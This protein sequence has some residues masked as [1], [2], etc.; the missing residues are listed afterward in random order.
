MTNPRKPLVSRTG[1]TIRSLGAT[2]AALL[3]LSAC[4]SSTPPE[5]VAPSIADTPASVN[6]NEV[7]GPH[8]PADRPLAERK[9]TE[10][11]AKTL[12]RIAIDFGN[13]TS[14]QF[15]A[16]KRG[17]IIVP[18][19]G[20]EASPLVILSHLRAPNCQDRTFAYPCAAGVEEF[21]Y[22]EGM[23]YLGDH[24]AEHGYTVVI[25]D[26]GAA[27]IGADLG[28]P[29]S[30][31]AMWEDIVG[32]M[33]NALR[34]D[35]AGQ[36]TILGT[37]IPRP[38]DFDTVGLVAHSRSGQMIDSAIKVAGQGHMKGVFAYGP[39]YDTVEL[40][41]I[42]PALADVPY[43]A[44]VGSLDSDVG[45]SANLLLGHYATTARTAP[46]SV[47]EV[48]G[49]G[50][51]YVNRAASAAQFDDRIGCDVL[52][53]PD[54]TEHERVMDAVATEWLNATLRNSQTA[55][56]QGAHDELPAEVAGLPARWLALT[57][58]TV[59][60]VDVQAFSGEKS[61]VCTFGDGRQANPCPEADGGFVQILTPI[62]HVD[63]SVSATVDVEGARGITLQI[64]PSGTY[65][66]AQGTPVKVTLTLADGSVHDFDIPGRHPAL[67]SRKTDEDD[68]T[69]R[70]G[71]VRI[72]LADL[73]ESKIVGV[74]VQTQEYPVEL[75]S[76]DFWK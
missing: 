35:S 4:T 68:G 44:V 31:T 21:R 48:P 61:V 46:A 38:V 8:A 62:V 70:L 28:E 59:A 69:Y 58:Q 1:L 26:L 55:L 49:L 30:Q 25:P 24:L 23:V 50:H 71:T 12:R 13:T 3:V 65:E 32:T 53:C 73:P 5:D 6:G 57:P 45:S 33:I 39:A 60:S 52:E 72:A 36:T 67:V 22:D 10:N 74:A 19:Q 15:S 27:Y 18:T 43:L 11:D 7:S 34:T 37:E 42:S 2:A 47:V 64:A 9:I 66:G 63:R 54:A 56:P 20:T 40:E 41:Y 76:V 75:R 51:M 29:Y 14:A 17:T 16:P